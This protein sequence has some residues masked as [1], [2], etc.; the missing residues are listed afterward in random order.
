MFSIW[1]FFFLFVSISP[2]PQSF[3]GSNIWIWSETPSINHTNCPSPCSI[4]DNATNDTA[5]IA[6]ISH[7]IW[8][9]DTEIRKRPDSF[10]SCSNSIHHPSSFCVMDAT[11]KGNYLSCLYPALQ[12]PVHLFIWNLNL[13]LVNR[14]KEQMLCSNATL[15]QHS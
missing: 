14:L 1:F 9:S 8:C 10:C 3:M 13:V 12:F 2:E 4:H 15:L 5:L 6:S 11:F 7:L